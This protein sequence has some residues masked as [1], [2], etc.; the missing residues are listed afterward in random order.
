MITAVWEPGFC[1]VNRKSTKTADGRIQ[2]EDR[3]FTCAILIHKPLHHMLVGVLSVLVTIPALVLT[4]EAQSDQAMTQALDTVRVTIAVQAT[5][6]VTIVE[7][8]SVQVMS[9]VLV[10][11]QDQDTTVE[12]QLVQVMIQALAMVQVTIVAARSAAVM[13]Q[14]RDTTVEVQSEAVMIQVLAMILIQGRDTRAEVQSEAVMI[15]VLAMIQDQDT[16]VEA[17]SG[18]A[19][20]QVQVMHQDTTV[21]VDLDQAVNA[22]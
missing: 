6:Q 22:I 10:M 12:A 5:D 20:I 15:Q 1:V 18:A 9:L 11:I 8:Q 7:M 16:T 17:Q 19:T 2:R 13:T 4:V 14:D 21:E 3:V